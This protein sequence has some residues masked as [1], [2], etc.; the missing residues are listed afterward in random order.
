M[1]RV[2]ILNTYSW[3]NKGDTAI[4]L[5]II[6]ALRTN[7]PQV[8]ISIVSATPEV[9]AP[10]YAERSI[11]VVGDPLWDILRTDRSLLGRIARF[12]L[13]LVA[14]PLSLLSTRMLGDRVRLPLGSEARAL[15]QR[16]SEADVA[17]SCGGGFWVDSARR[18]IYVHLFEVASA[19]LAGIPVICL[20]QSIGPLASGWRRW[21]VGRILSRTA[22]VVVR[23]RESLKVARDLRIGHRILHLGTDMAFAL[24]PAEESQTPTSRPGERLRVGVTA[25]S[26]LF[27][28]SRNRQ[29]AQ[30]QYER[31]LGTAIDNLIAHC[32]ADVVFLPQVINPPA[33]D[34]RIVQRRIAA[35]LK[36]PEHI[37]MLEEDLAPEELIR[38]MAGLDLVIATRFHS[39]ILSMLAHVPVV[40]IAYEHKTTGIM[41]EMGLDHWV[42]PIESVTGTELFRLCLE[43]IEKR[44]TVSNYLAVAVT[45]QRRRAHSSLQLSLD[46]VANKSHGVEMWA[47]V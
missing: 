13:N 5:G 32:D 47:E 11:D 46:A 39:A 14:V 21:A 23:E 37:E 31:Q 34:D 35:A 24:A 30:L 7:F 38:Y 10:H 19:L 28:G 6:Q 41:A 25:R 40:A 22:A 44:D 29:Q 8:E 26:W 20:G 2:V 18:G 4:V 17:I 36:R 27:P 3:L 1:R 16:V 43:L 42:L 9:D 12:T 33:D 45:E 15:V